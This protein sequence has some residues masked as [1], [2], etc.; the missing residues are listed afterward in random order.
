MKEFLAYVFTLI[1]GVVLGVFLESRA[2][3]FYQRRS[4]LPQPSTP[5][6][7]PEVV[8]EPGSDPYRCGGD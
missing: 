3:Q 2:R 5:P 8:V 4:K 1:I 7:D 6:L